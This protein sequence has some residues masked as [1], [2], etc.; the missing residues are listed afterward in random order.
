MWNLFQPF[1]NGPISLSEVSLFGIIA[2]HFRCHSV[3][4]IRK[5]EHL[6]ILNLWFKVNFR[7]PMKLLNLWD[8]PEQTCNPYLIPCL[9][10]EFGKNLWYF[11]QDL[12]CF[13][14]CGVLIKFHR[15]CKI[16]GCR[17]KHH[18]FFCQIPQI[19]SWCYDRKI[20]IT[21]QH[22]PNWFIPW[23]TDIAIFLIYTVSSSE[24]IKVNIFILLV[25]I[26]DDSSL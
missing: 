13:K 4:H 26:N 1:K 10:H 7:H 9:N 11:T 22:F 23:P 6:R 2:V 19:L 15:F 25:S 14:I 5:A 21:W 24:K 8:L 3:I 18:S 12:I 20:I 17:L 16:C